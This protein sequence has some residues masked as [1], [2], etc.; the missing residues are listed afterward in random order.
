MTDEKH[1]GGN[2]RKRAWLGS[3]GLDGVSGLED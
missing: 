3:G 2:Q 1:L